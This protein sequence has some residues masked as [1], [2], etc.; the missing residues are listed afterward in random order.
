[1]PAQADRSWAP[2]SY[3]AHE[4]LI[5]GT[6][7]TFLG[8]GWDRMFLASGQKRTAD[9]FNGLDPRAKAE[10]VCVDGYGHMDIYWGERAPRE[11]FPVIGAGLSRKP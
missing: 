1:V 11:V 5:D 8:A 9:F 10:Y 3:V 6:R 4:P 2:P 7:F